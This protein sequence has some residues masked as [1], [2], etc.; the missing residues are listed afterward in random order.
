M[1]WTEAFRDFLHRVIG[2]R[3]IPLAYVI[4]PEAN[5]PVA[6]PNDPGYPFAAEFGSVEAEL[7]ARASHTHPL[8]RDDNALLYYFIEEATR[9]TAYAAS[10]KPFQRTK[11]G[12]AAFN[13]LES[14]YAG[15]DKWRALL[16]QAEEMIH[17]RK[18]K[19][20]QSN[21][22]LEKYIGQ[23]RTA[24]VNMGQCATHVDYQLPN[25]ISRVTYLLAGIECMHPPLQAAMALVRS[26]QDPTGKMNN[27]EATASFLLPH[28]PVANKRTND[29]KRPAAEL[30][31]VSFD[32]PSDD[33]TKA[34]AGKTGVEF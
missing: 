17:S 12:R 25:K 5:V 14:Q 6:P 26:D 34:R 23:H 15:E 3:H 18:W 33:I 28:D 4:R 2:S 30:A 20:Q 21:F 32:I 9:G 22:S 19:G 1:K 24:F 7:I 29:R 27:F 10:I 8:Y 31:E 13:A 11:N 16:K